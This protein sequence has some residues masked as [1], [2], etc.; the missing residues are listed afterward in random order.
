MRPYRGPATIVREGTALHA[1]VD[2]WQRGDSWGG[3][4]EQDAGRV[5]LD[6]ERVR[7]LLPTGESAEALVSIVPAACVTYLVAAS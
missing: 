7:V 2:I 4:F 6:N 1:R 3:T 5:L